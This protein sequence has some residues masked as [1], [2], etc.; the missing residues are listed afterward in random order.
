MS[1][2]TRLVRPLLF[3]LD[4][5][6][7]HSRTIALARR[8]G[9]LS[10]GRRLMRRLYA[11]DLP[12]LQCEVAGMNFANPMGMAAGF[13]K[14]GRAIQALAAMGFGFVE[15]G[16]VSAH[17]SDGNPRPRL[18]RLPED[19]AIVVN[20]G[21]PNDGAEVVAGRVAHTPIPVPLGVNL[22]ETNTG[23]ALPAEAV[24]A[25]LVEA[26]RPF[27]GVADYLALN[28]N[29]PNTTGGISPFE[30]G[31]VLRDLMD[32]YAGLADLPPV[33]L[34]F[35]AHADPARIDRMLE[36]VEPFGFVAG[37]IFNLPSGKAYQLR[38]PAAVV[39]AMPGTLCGP[40]TRDLLDSAIGGWYG[41][42]DHSR[43]RIIGS[44]GVV[45]AEDAYRKIRL[46]ASL[47]QVYTALIY[48]G[49]GLLRRICVGLARLL[50]RDGLKA[51][52]EAVGV[53]ADQPPVEG[54]TM[55]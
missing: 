9:A 35:T 16:S 45:S 44:G 53:G 26:A 55:Q 30:D 22:V 51:I 39:E 24:V 27:V 12:Q 43:Y 14:N 50:E 32:G 19:E 48:Q 18:L 10:L 52:G 47:V 41:R 7:V 23:Q 13:D 5:E 29:C 8:L 1:A 2:Y 33:F 49:P 40:P 34:K 54:R 31:A 38:S 37:F 15:I 20:Y 36:A 3:R 6:R 28:L 17:S 4:A 46:G 11:C 21:V 42:M 25:E